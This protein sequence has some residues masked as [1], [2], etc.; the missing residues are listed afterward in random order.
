MVLKIQHLALQVAPLRQKTQPAAAL[1]LDMSLAEPAG[2]HD[3]RQGQ[4]ICRIGLVA[5]GR[6]RRA[7]M[8][9]LQGHCRQAAL[10][11]LGLQPGR[12]RSGFMTGTPQPWQEPLEGHR[13]HVLGQHLGLHL[14]LALVVDHADRRPRSTR[15]DLRRTPSPVSCVAASPQ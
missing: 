8:L 5:L 4:R 10:D 3:V 2:P 12:Q 7:H 14:H 11:E 13:D 15:R 6:H 9:G 1:R